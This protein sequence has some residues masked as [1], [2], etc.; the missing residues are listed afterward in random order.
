ME[1]AAYVLHLTT[2]D[3][4]PIGR[5][6]AEPPVHLPLA[7]NLAPNKCSSIP[8]DLPSGSGVDE[9]SLAADRM[10]SQ[11]EKLQSHCH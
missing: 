7:G 1:L 3:T 6:S 10:G 9:E 11:T 5:Q 4:L 2:S 8:L